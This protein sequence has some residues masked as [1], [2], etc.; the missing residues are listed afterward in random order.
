MI[1]DLDIIPQL[2]YLLSKYNFKEY[3]F[4]HL[5]FP[6]LIKQIYIFEKY[7]MRLLHFNV[8][9]AAVREA[10]AVADTPNQFPHASTYRS[11]YGS[12]QYSC[13]P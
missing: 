5:F 4:F 1:C 13:R 10:F 7:L 8:L 12:K 2:T 11:L 9:H 6:S 3:V